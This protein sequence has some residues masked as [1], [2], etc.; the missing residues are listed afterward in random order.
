MR[1]P[2]SNA[3]TDGAGIFRQAA[4]DRYQRDLMSSKEGSIEAKVLK[5]LKDCL[6]FD[7]W[8][9]EHGITDDTDAKH[10][11]K[12]L[13]TCCKSLSR[14]VQV[15]NHTFYG[16]DFKR[17][18]CALG[19][20]EK[21]VANMLD[22]EDEQSVPAMLLFF[23]ALAKLADVSV[24]TLS[25]AGLGMPAT[26]V[27]K[28]KELQLLGAVARAYVF[29]LTGFDKSISEHL[30]SLAEM[31]AIIFVLQRRSSTKFLPN[32]N[33]T[34]TS[35]MIRAKFKSVALAQA[36]GIS[37]YYIFLD[38]D[39]ML[40]GF[41]GVLRT[42]SGNQRN[43]DLLQLE[44][45]AT[46][47]MQIADVFL[48]HPDWDRGSRRLSGSL[49]HWNTKSWTGCTDTSKVN[50]VQAWMSGL[51]RGRARL[52]GT[53]LFSADEL[54]FAALA[55]SGKDISMLMPN[56]ERIGAQLTARA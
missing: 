56:G 9:G 31:Q 39:D 53:A 36:E 12:C 10:D 26:L 22:P 44:E 6:L 47:A 8:S 24:E 11:A 54:D 50:V 29:L 27:L 14:G 20:S 51:A 30:V 41:F 21:E 52:V 4:V 35:T 13:R 19:H 1:G 46:H 18:L 5:V 37:T 15:V 55:A 2:I 23:K 25:A 28:T 42:L 3:S 40:E 38:C 32:Q 49:D 34:N 43:F 16:S 48:R 33:Y 17:I 7:L 45:K